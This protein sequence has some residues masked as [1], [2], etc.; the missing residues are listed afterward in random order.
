MRY[1]LLEMVLVVNVDLFQ[2]TEPDRFRQIAVHTSPRFHLEIE[3]G[4]YKE[5]Y[6][7]KRN[8]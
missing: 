2:D 4:Y 3:N 6:F 1:K 8:C 5:W 7:E